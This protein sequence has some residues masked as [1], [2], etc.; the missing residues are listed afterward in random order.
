MYIGRYCI[1]CR[2]K[3][4]EVCRHPDIIDTFGKLVCRPFLFPIKSGKAE[5]I[6]GMTVKRGPFTL[7]HRAVAI[8]PHSLVV[9]R[10]GK[11]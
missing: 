11:G 8:D 3:L 5:F 4:F 2:A 7:D 9:M 6:N 10:N 1:D